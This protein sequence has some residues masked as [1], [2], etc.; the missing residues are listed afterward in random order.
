MLHGAFTPPY[1]PAFPAQM[2]GSISL[3]G[4]ARSNC[5]HPQSISLGKNIRGCGF[6]S[7]EALAGA[8]VC[9]LPT[10]EIN[11]GTTR[12]HANVF[13][14]PPKFSVAREG[15]TAHAPQTSLKVAAFSNL[16]FDSW[17]GA[18]HCNLLSVRMIPINRARIQV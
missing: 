15:S 6:A 18:E 10:T 8:A 3:C 7:C 11:R 5:A 17:T 2:P 14:Q 16:S 1:C 12:I 13:I 4:G 9:A